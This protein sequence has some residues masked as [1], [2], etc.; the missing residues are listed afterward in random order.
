MSGSF[1][2]DRNFPFRE[3]VTTNEATMIATTLATLIFFQPLDDAGRKVFIDTMESYA[4]LD[5]F[6]V[7]IEH[8]NSS[9]LFSGKYIQHLDFKKDKG[10]KLTVTS[11]QGK[12]RPQN[13]APDYYCDGSDVTTVGRFDGTRPINKDTNTSPGYEVSGGIIMMW[14][15]DSPGKQ[16]FSKPP[17]GMEIE[18]MS[19]RRNTWKDLKVTEILISVKIDAKDDKST[20][21]A[22]L[23]ADKR[24]LLGYEW[25]RD[26]KTGTLLYK[27]QMN[28]PSVNVKSFKPPVK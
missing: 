28:N 17:A 22:F 2:R 20:L 14:L 5:S 12:E 26:E 19:G 7:D 18:L 15:M 8:D 6:S 16:F 23:D 3:S 10:F 25:T 11:L 13:V 9:G 21:S 1:S 4:K 24:K 27:N